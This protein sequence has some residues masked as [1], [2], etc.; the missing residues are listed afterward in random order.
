M[1]KRLLSLLLCAA[2]A[3]GLCA[4]ALAAE[5][6]DDELTRVTL[7]VK[8]TLSIGSGYSDFD[9]TLQD[10]GALRR[11]QLRWSDQSGDAVTVL[12]ADDGKVLQYNAGGGNVWAG[13]GD[14]GAYEPKLSRVTADSARAAASAFLARVLTGAESGKVLSSSGGLI[15]ADYNFR[16]QIL[17]NGVP[18]AAEATMVVGAADGKV[19]YYYRSDSYSAHVNALPSGTPAVSAAAA[20]E[21]LSG[22]VTFDLRYVLDGAGKAVLRYV[23]AQNASLYVDAQTGALTDLDEAWNNAARTGTTGA[24]QAAAEEADSAAGLSDAEQAAIAQLKGVLSKEKLDAA[25]RAV[26]ALGLGRYTFSSSS[27][28]ADK[29]TGAVTCTLRYTRPLAF[30]ELTGVDQSDYREGEY[31]QVRAIAVDAKTGKLLE[32]WGYRPWYMKP[33]SADRAS[34]KAKADAFLAF[35]Q[36]ERAKSTALADGDGADFSYE[37]QV[38][39]YAYPDN[40]VFLSLDPSDGSAETFRC[41]WN[42]DLVFDSA[43]GLVSAAAAKSAYFAAWKATLRY[44]DYPVSVD[45]SVPMWKTYADNCGSAAYRYVLGYTYETDR[46]QILGVDAKTGKLVLSADDAS[47]AAYT[48]L[49]GSYAKTQIAALAAGGVRFGASAKFQPAKILTEKD[50]LVLLLN[51]CG[52]SFDADEMKDEDSL[53]QLYSAAW[54]RGFLPRGQQHPAS[55]VTRIALLRAIVGASPYGR[56]AELPGIF[57]VSFSDAPKLA[58]KDVGCAAIAQGL[59][60]VRGD[61][62]RRLNPNRAATRQEA[63]VVLYNYMNQ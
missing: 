58:A 59:G 5:S 3:L 27:Y 53:S 52:C 33:V 50:M 46:G 29:K 37:R 48:D 61:A 25:V 23:P 39:G 13:R 19:S 60:L 32:G 40:G 1:K 20:A 63:A 41:D 57:R 55:A 34:L 16:A 6:M 45:V 62:Q 15:G 49:A 14:S 36:P 35:W 42:D 44:V 18:S 56:A 31:Q 10:M 7:S 9:G 22:A 38:N 28:S 54:D 26:S 12:A 24:K 51:S 4:P 17:L 8:N 30:S 47:S 21:K 2:L 43:D 11:W